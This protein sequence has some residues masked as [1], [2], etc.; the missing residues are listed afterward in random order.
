MQAMPL[1]TERDKGA[2]LLRR[3]GLGASEAE[4]DFYLR[5]GLEGAID[6]LLNYEHIEEPYDYDIVDMLTL[7]QRP[8]NPQVISA[9]WTLKL[10]TTRR[11]LQEKMTVFWHNHFATSAE[12]VTVGATMQDQIDLLRSFATSSFPTLLLNV[13]KDPAMLYWLDNQYNVKGKPN[14]NFAREVMELFTLGEGQGY[15]ERDVKEAARAFTGWTAGGGRRVIEDL[16]PRGAQFVFNP[17]VHDDGEKT[18]LGHTGP[19]KGE[20]IVEI[21]CETPR[22]AEFLVNKIW[23]WFVY[24]KPEPSLVKRFAE[25]FRR[26]GMDIKPLLGSIMRSP[27]FYSAKA[28]RAV[29]KNPVDFVIPTLRQLGVGPILAARVSEEADFQYRRLGP[30]VAATAAMKQMGMQLLYP[31]DVSGWPRGS[32]WVSSA[33]MVARIGWADRLFGQAVGPG[34]N[35]FTAFEIFQADPSPEGIAAKLVS[36]FDA[37][38]PKERMPGLV[39]AARKASG[40]RLTEGNANKTADAVARLLFATPEFQFC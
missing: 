29:Y 18:V 12:K 11:P 34:L 21:L 33:T 7:D 32:A 30:V 20:D 40:S 3:F 37:P 24:P 1:V 25:S 14:E 23:E 6:R 5:N 28:E 15:T 9:W 35:E 8:P 38:L 22:T 31:P 27:E 4:L 13:S 2:H 10:I 19:L 36:I 26:S 17:S 16:P 39:E